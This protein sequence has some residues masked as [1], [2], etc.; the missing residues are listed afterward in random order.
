[1]IDETTFLNIEKDYNFIF[2]KLCGSVSEGE[3]PD[4]K[5]NKK[6]FAFPTQWELFI[7]CAIMGYLDGKPQKIKKKQPLFRWQFISGDHRSSII[8]FAINSSKSLEIV[9]DKEL[10]RQNIEEHANRGLELLNKKLA[11]EPL[12]FN[13]I[14]DLIHQIQ[15]RDKGE[16]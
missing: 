8:I 7:W 10:L 16:T 14:E 3:N 11:L 4:S 1:M 6:D 2:K 9:N 15:Q 5:K 12:A 13:N